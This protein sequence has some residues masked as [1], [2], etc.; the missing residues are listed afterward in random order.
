M[1]WSADPSKAHHEG[2]EKPIYAWVPSIGSSQ[3]IVVKGK[4]FQQWA[5]DLLVSSLVAQ[6]LFRTRL[7]EGRAVVV[8]PI[9]IGHRIRDLV[10]L[11]SGVIALKTDDDLLAFL[12]PVDNA[13][14]TVLEPEAHGKVMAASCAGCHSLAP[15][16]TDGMGP[17]LW[18]IVGRPVASRKGFTY[19]HALASMR[20]VWTRERLRAFISNP[21]AVAPG[22][23]MRRTATYNSRSVD[24]LIAYL[25]TLR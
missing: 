8:E 16:G 6:T 18:G 24:D 9:P 13:R 25:A 20:G 12:E 10:E 17:A 1:I 5:G 15:D 11:S 14:V 4:A 2:F 23:P 7:A 21:E 3:L 19:S 22:T